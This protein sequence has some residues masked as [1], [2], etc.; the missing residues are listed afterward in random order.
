[1]TVIQHR[2]KYVVD[3]QILELSGDQKKVRVTESLIFREMDLKQQ[4]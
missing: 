1:M 3:S 2:L 4:K